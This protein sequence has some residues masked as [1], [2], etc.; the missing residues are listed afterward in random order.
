M[1]KKPKTGP[2]KTATGPGSGRGGFR[3]G[4]GRKPLLPDIAPL[5]DRVAAAEYARNYVHQCIDELLHIG[6]HSPSDASR[7]AALDKV[8][9][10]AL[11]AVPQGL[12]L[13]NRDND[14]LK[15]D[16]GFREFAQALNN[17]A[18]VKSEQS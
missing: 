6:L 9:C 1:A 3:K 11:G 7:I 17:I 15:I 5:E 2:K 8:L 14:P 13:A 18:K 10:R 4:S 12:E 16:A